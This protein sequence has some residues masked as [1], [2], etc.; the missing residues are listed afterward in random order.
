MKNAVAEI[1]IG[2]EYDYAVVNDTIDA[3]VEKIKAILVAER[4]KV[5]RNA[6]KFEL[7]GDF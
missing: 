3:A 1:Q 2:H 7:E 4:C 5:A 6:E